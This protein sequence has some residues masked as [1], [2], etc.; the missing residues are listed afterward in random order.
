M[1]L[2]KPDR[3][4]A[5]I[6]RID[7][8]RDILAQGY[9]FA[10]LDID[11]TILSRETSAIPHD[12]GAWLARARD[13]GITFCLVSNNWHGSVRELADEL[14][15]PIVAK[16]MKPFPAAF[17]AAR[18]KIGARR[19][20]TLVIGDQLMTDVVGAHLAGMKAYLVAPLV[21]KDLPHTLA[22][23]K[24]ERLLMGDREPEGATAATQVGSVSEG[25]G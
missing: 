16:A 20:E 23:R 15:L 18:G 1:A 19:A 10:L 8:E 4:F 11:N 2:F 5:R 9:R 24:I 12:V 3:Y 25:R 21:E 6:T 22:L 13:A 17:V 14:G 7:I